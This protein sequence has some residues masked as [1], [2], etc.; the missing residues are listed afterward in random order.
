MPKVTTR[1]GAKLNR[2]LRS[3]KRKIRRASRHVDV[4]FFESARYPPVRTGADGG[5][6]QAAVPVAAV[7]AW[8]E[9]GTRKNGKQHT[10]ERPFMRNAIRNSLRDVKEIIRTKVEGT[11]ENQQAKLVGESIKGHIQL[12]I[13]NFRDPDNAPSTKARKDKQGRRTKVLIDT[14]KMRNSVTWKVD[15]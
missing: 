10:P 6:K 8:N 7:A 2:Y 14:G 3:T 5:Q 15:G 9:F 13:T 11:I 1:G 4:G 12:E